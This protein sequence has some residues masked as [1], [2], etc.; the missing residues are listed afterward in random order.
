VAAQVQAFKLR[1]GQL[2]G[3]RERLTQFEGLEAG[4]QQ[5]FK[6]QLEARI[7]ALEAQLTLNTL[8]GAQKTAL[9]T[10]L[11][12]GGSG[13][14]TRALLE[15]LIDSAGPTE[16]QALARTLSTVRADLFQAPTLRAFQALHQQDPAALRGL[17]D[18]LAA[19][20]PREST[21]L[22]LLARAC[23]PQALQRLRQWAQGHTRALEKI[24]K[25]AR[26]KGVRF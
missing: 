18:D 12:E 20:R 5:P 16:I 6:A 23:D 9:C 19:H 17:L 10:A 14:R 11:C 1:E 2:R 3:L 22:T 8:S 4:Y 24:D 15:R 26:E 25:V 7:S 21:R 13:R